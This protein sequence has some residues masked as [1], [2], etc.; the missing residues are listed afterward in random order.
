MKKSGMYPELSS[1]LTP[2]LTPD[3][4]LHTHTHERALLTGTPLL[5]LR[6][7]VY[8]ITSLSKGRG[9]LKLLCQ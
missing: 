3:P 6:S 4:Q 2:D 8:P 1:D 7:Q 5:K 9:V